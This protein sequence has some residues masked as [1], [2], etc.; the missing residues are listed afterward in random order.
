MFLFGCI[1][2]FLSII[3]FT[4]TMPFKTFFQRGWW[5]EDRGR[6]FPRLLK[7]AANLSLEH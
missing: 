4:H 5:S 7:E 1:L 3:S 2:A 6:E